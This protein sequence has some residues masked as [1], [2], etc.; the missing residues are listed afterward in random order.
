MD[1]L[2]KQQKA[3]ITEYIRVLDPK[4]AALKAGYSKSCAKRQGESLLKSEKIIK[5][6]DTALNKQ[7]QT[8]QV[9]KAY[10]VKRLISIIEFSLAQEEI[11]D[12]DGNKTGKT[13][14]RDTQSSLR[15]LDFLCKHLGM[16]S[17]DDNAAS[18]EPKIT[19]IDNLNENKI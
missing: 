14:L 5:A 4:E 12:K 8:L 3:F 13:K 18:C 2:T 16:A 17:P 11:C 1:D 7:A 6:I 10:I 19:F 15:A 9:S